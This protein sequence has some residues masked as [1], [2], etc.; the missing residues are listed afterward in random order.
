MFERV[1]KE[2]RSSVPDGSFDWT[3]WKSGEEDKYSTET[4]DSTYRRCLNILAN[5]VGKIAFEV[6]QDN[7][8]G[9]CVLKSHPLYEILRLRPNISMSA[10]DCFGA[11]IR[12][13]K[14]Y[15]IAGLYID[16]EVYSGKIKG[17]YPVRINNI[18]VDDR[19]GIIKSKKIN[20]VMVEFTCLG[21]MGYCSEE[22]II[23]I[24][25]NSLNGIDGEA[26]RTYLKDTL[27][28]NNKGR[29]Y[30]RE[31]FNNGLTSKLAIQL[32]SDV[33]DEHDLVK[34]QNKFNRMY[35]SNGRVFT[36]PAGFQVTPLNLSLA[37]SQFAELKLIGKKEVSSV[38][39]IPYSLV[40]DMKNISEDDI[41]SMISVSIH[42]ILIALEQECDWKL[43]SD[44]DRSKNIKCRF[45]ING[46]LRTSPKT[47]QEI[48]CNYV[49]QGVYSL[50]Y[51]K[52][53]L[54]AELLDEDVTVFPSGQVTLEQLV[55]GKVSY[56]KNNE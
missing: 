8:T 47:Q 12:L 50:N 9:E 32:M 7:I 54:G 24:R 40:D 18:T 6:K 20:R 3:K 55:N 31:L 48:I 4:K 28:S 38:L 49:K 19:E 52:K 14:H 56:I 13:Y 22:N 46:L 25:D 29:K 34:I 33:K 23:I 21:K 53:I 45:N 41:L 30:Q 43:L 2:K 44:K 51:A 26:D 37:D 11:L 5:L 10:Y 17:L 16:K 27:Y 42:P 36:I 1:L 39:G 15:G 35:S